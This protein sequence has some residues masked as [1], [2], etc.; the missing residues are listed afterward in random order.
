MSMKKGITFIATLLILACVVFT[1]SGAWAASSTTPTM[2]QED[3]TAYKK[4]D[5]T[6]APYN[7]IS[8][9]NRTI[10]YEG[11]G[12]SGVLGGSDITV[13]GYQYYDKDG[14]GEP[15]FVAYKD[16][17]IPPISS[18]NSCTYSAGTVKGNF[19]LLETIGDEESGLIG[20]GIVKLEVL[21]KGMDA[22]KSFWLEYNPP[23]IDLDESFLPDTGS[24]IRK[25]FVATITSADGDTLESTTMDE[26]GEDVERPVYVWMKSKLAGSEDKNYKVRVQSSEFSKS[27]SLV[28][29]P[30]SQTSD[31][32]FEV[33]DESGLSYVTDLDEIGG[34]V[35]FLQTIDPQQSSM[36][37]TT[38]VALVNDE[39]VLMV[40]M[41]A[42]ALD[43]DEVR[44]NKLN[45]NGKFITTN[46]D[47]S[48]ADAEGYRYLVVPATEDVD[49][50]AWGSAEQ[51]TLAVD[52]DENP[53]DYDVYFGIVDGSAPVLMQALRDEVN[54]RTLLIFNE[55]LD[56]SAPID[57]IE[58]W[59][60]SSDH[61][62]VK[63]TGKATYSTTNANVIVLPEKLAVGYGVRV[64]DI[65]DIDEIYRDQ[66]SLI[67]DLSGNRIIER[68]VSVMNGLR[69]KEVRVTSVG[70][71][72]TTIDIQFSGDLDLNT[73][74][75][76]G[77][78]EY[79]L[80]KTSA[81]KL[82]L[83]EDDLATDWLFDSD[84]D[85]T[86]DALRYSK[87]EDELDPVPDEADTVRLTINARLT[88]TSD[89][90]LPQVS[91]SSLGATHIKGETG[92]LLVND[93]KGVAS[94]D[95]VGP[96][97]VSASYNKNPSNTQLLDD[98]VKN[99]VM[100]LTFSEPI[101]CGAVY[102]PRYDLT[103]VD[104]DGNAF[105]ED[106]AFGRHAEFTPRTGYSAQI[107]V[108][109]GE[110]YGDEEDEQVIP[111][112]EGETRV[113]IQAEKGE[114]FRDKHDNP[115]WARDMEDMGLEE[116]VRLVTIK[117]GTTPWIVSVST[118]DSS[119][120][121]G[122]EI[123]NGQIE[124][125]RV[126]WSEPVDQWFDE[127]VGV[128]SVVGYSLLNPKTSSIDIVDDDTV[129][130]MLKERVDMPDTSAR[131][132]LTLNLAP[133]V[134][135]YEEANERPEGEEKLRVDSK[136]VIPSS[137]I[138]DGA[139]PVP[140]KVTF[141]KTKSPAAGTTGTFE[142]TFRVK[143]SEPIDPNV[144]SDAEHDASLDFEIRGNASGS[145]E[146]ALADLTIG[147]YI[148]HECEQNPT[149]LSFKVT[150]TGNA[151]I[152]ETDP[153]PL[154]VM[155]VE[156]GYES[157][158]FD[159]ADMG[160]DDWQIGVYDKNWNFAA[161]SA[162]WSDRPDDLEAQKHEIDGGLTS[163]VEG[164]D[165]TTAAGT[166]ILRG[167]IIGPD[168]DPVEPAVAEN[169]T[170]AEKWRIYAYSLNNLFRYEHSRHLEAQHDDEDHPDWVTGYE[171]VDGTVVDPNSAAY[172]R[173]DM[174]RQVLAPNTF[175]EGDDAE[176]GVCFGSAYV[177]PNGEYM[178]NIYGD[179]LGSGLEDG[180]K[181]GEPI[182]L[183]VETPA[184]PG[185]DITPH[186]YLVTN[187]C[188]NDAGFY[189]EWKDNEYIA[190]DIDLTKYEEIPLK[191]GWNLVSFS[192]LKRYVLGDGKV[193]GTSLQVNV[194]GTWKDIDASTLVKAASV[195]MVIPSL[196]QQWSRIFTV[197][198]SKSDRVDALRVTEPV[199]TG[200]LNFTGGV[201]YFS[202]GYGYWI[203]I[204]S[205]LNANL[206]VLGDSLRDSTNYRLPVNVGVYGG[207]NL[208]GYWGQKVS[209]TY[210]PYGVG[211]SSIFDADEADC[212]NQVSAISE[213]FWS[214]G[215]K[216]DGVRT[217]YQNDPTN[218]DSSKISKA[219]YPAKPGRPE[220]NE[221]TYVGPGFGYWVRITDEC[222]VMW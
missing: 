91:I 116:F 77:D 132:S 8:Q 59:K 213:A 178:M 17:H 102:F 211:F 82:A 118:V 155:P 162:I 18:V 57:G 212:Y 130:V 138:T 181:S 86:L 88:D 142:Y 186:K 185:D 9:D 128:A 157:A 144:W 42:G 48:Q 4:G 70:E 85:G 12:Y 152:N 90:G 122:E 127:P 56:K 73:P 160:P 38:E 166:M 26:T 45:V 180:F 11:T 163:A 115:A 101:Q 191:K 203:N 134:N 103:L 173:Y 24:Q 99:H 205:V 210:L 219:W 31:L 150:Y 15:E 93:N 124:A 52:N 84:G 28:I 143:Y 164:H 72:F 68:E 216:L 50:Y 145:A 7:K 154:Y 172:D 201:E 131:P 107:Q 95:A 89:A 114:G 51:V 158:A 189:V 170:D 39:P 14:D 53:D 22:P 1:G 141:Q 16:F 184:E 6:Q 5:K 27:V 30:L 78:A 37:A 33:K 100:T 81:D 217:F 105:D 137:G 123:G 156:T 190:H 94:V 136:I 218:M 195:D 221:I 47:W 196:Y 58:V 109:M 149:T 200:Q 147:E 119:I 34:N 44:M 79:Y 75:E 108:K 120:H 126:V 2:K 113:R 13:V 23:A 32:R 177:D 117:D 214:I 171:V 46:N 121:D 96:Y 182:Y 112:I 207:W 60:S 146:P 140:L 104:R 202:V 208:L 25:F 129:D 43:F 74:A 165:V 3:V 110:N 49:V 133:N 148:V 169:P 153:T 194:D 125:L 197:N 55:P 220:L 69:V 62:F 209:Y 64:G 21:I 151:P 41:P 135:Y 67:R 199:T 65:G 83:P 97:I 215:S 139:R 222:D 193:A 206:V 66:Q 179:M 192:T 76:W 71:N 40:K 204:P 187:G 98:D 10:Y 29:D 161:S 35:S 20:E 167:K 159:P 111:V 61:E 198:P 92:A 19:T 174:V 54:N 106:L 87:I 188:K 36:L 175:T 176:N 183:V 168:G 80:V 63:Y